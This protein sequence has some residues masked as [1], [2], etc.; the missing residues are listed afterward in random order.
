MS[1]DP[2]GGAQAAGSWAVRETFVAVVVS[3]LPMVY[4]GYL[5]ITKSV[6]SSGIFS[7][8]RSKGYSGYSR[9][10]DDHELPP[11]S[12]ETQFYSM[13]RQTTGNAT[14]PIEQ[15]SVVVPKSLA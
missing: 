5:R 13:P 1:K 4:Q 11:L 2:I 3:N 6:S 12:K 9:S 14:H 7:R 8:S 15:H 10:R